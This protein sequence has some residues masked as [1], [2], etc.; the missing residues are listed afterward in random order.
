MSWYLVINLGLS[1]SGVEVQEGYGQRPTKIRIPFD[2]EDAAEFARRHLDVSIVQ[3]PRVVP[4]TVLVLS[5]E[6]EGSDDQHQ[7]Q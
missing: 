7:Q 1:Y 5:P 3:D 4:G 2:F 6:I